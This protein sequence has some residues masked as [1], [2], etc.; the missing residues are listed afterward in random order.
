MS[1]L[2]IV[3]PQTVAPGGTARFTATFYTP[4]G[5]ARDVT[6]ESVWGSTSGELVVV[7]PGIVNGQ[8]AGTVSLRASFNTL[9]STREVIIV[10][11]G[12]YRLTGVVSDPDAP[13]GPV[14]G[15]RVEVTEGPGRGLVAMTS[16][17]G[18][19][20]LYGIAGQATLRVTKEGYE[21]RVESLFVSGHRAL[22]FQLLILG[23]RSDVSG[24]Y[25]LTIAADDTCAALLP[26]EAMSR[27]YSAELTQVGPALTIA[28]SGAR[29]AEIGGRPLNVIQGV[30]NLNGVRLDLGNL[31]CS[32]YYYGCGPAL[33]E[34]L[35]AGTFFVPWG[36]LS[37]S[38]S[39]TRLTGELNGHLQVVQGPVPVDFFF[40][41]IA[42]CRSSRHR[43]AFSR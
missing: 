42:S 21:P 6:A 9:I 7:A 43:V 38:M 32:G 14:A 35:S 41:P 24:S 3:G 30:V 16:S 40:T 12:T 5:S 15:A 18:D 22:N 31:G 26:A 20:A 1:R 19:Y 8:T 39:P 13:G 4:N 34:Q 11:D 29:F 23:R 25:K 33:V 17:T 28:V 36:S 27:T 10:P 37:L 2:E